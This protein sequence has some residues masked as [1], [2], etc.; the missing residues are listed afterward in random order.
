MRINAHL[1]DMT[2]KGKFLS[3]SAT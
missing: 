2:L 1:Y 3:I